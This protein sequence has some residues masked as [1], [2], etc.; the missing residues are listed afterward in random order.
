MSEVFF[1]DKKW[2]FH[3][4]RKM[5][6]ALTFL[7]NWKLWY[8]PSNP[9]MANI[10]LEISNKGTR[11]TLA[12]FCKDF[13]TESKKSDTSNWVE[14]SCTPTNSKTT[15]I[16]Q[17]LHHIWTGWRYEMRYL[18]AAYFPIYSLFLLL[19]RLT[20]ACSFRVFN[21]SFLN[22][23]SISPIQIDLPTK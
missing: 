20:P 22:S 15:V 18:K 23:Y 6:R 11:T 14:Y 16:N 13:Q 9:S 3:L 4:H 2:N 1:F 12:P 10:I 5:L 21:P 8:E 17:L 7:R 19:H